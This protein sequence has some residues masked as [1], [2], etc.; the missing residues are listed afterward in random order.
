MIIGYAI[1]A[2]VLSSFILLVFSI[3]KGRHELS[4]L[5]KGNVNRHSLLSFAVIAGFFLMF[6]LLFVHP[7][8]QLYFDENIYQ[9][10]AVNI[11][12]SGQALWCQYGTGNLNVCYVDSLYH[13]PAAWSVF[14]AMAFGVFGTTTSTAYALELLVGILSIAGVFLLSSILLKNKYA[15]VFSTAVFALMPELFIWARTQADIDLPFMML[16][17]FAFF[18]FVVFSQKPNKKTFAMFSFSAVLAVYMRIEGILLIPLF[19]ILF[20][21]F[22]DSGILK[23]IKERLKLVA[24]AL[25]NDIKLL[26]LLVLVLLL[27]MPAIYYFSI[28]SSQPSYGQPS[29]QSVISL[30]NF[31]HNFPINAGYLL[32]EFNSIGNYPTAFP[33]LVFPL[34]LAGM[35]A[36]ALFS[37]RE[38]R[39]GIL[40][41]LV[42]WFATYFIFYTAFYAGAATYGVDVRF[43]LSLMPCIA[44]LAA[45]P[46]L[47]ITDKIEDSKSG[48][49]KSPG[50]K[51]VY[52]AII[53]SAF[54]IIFVLFPFVMLI[55]NVTILPQNMPQQSVILNAMNFFYANYS[56]VPSNCLV[57][58]F[59]PEI[60]Y[61]VNRT[62]AEINY[63]FGANQSLESTFK[64]YSC[65]VV[66]YGYW[67]V[68]PPY[69][70]TTC[71]QAKS[72]Y[73]ISTIAS[74]GAGNGETVAFY[75]IFG[76]S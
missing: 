67:C 58:S 23:T 15:A 11:L 30:N 10:I 28:E 63:L 72:A 53:F 43:M 26:L 7:A 19:L 42:F 50:R 20:F 48:E 75:R 57:F 56:K 8:E 1:T 45:L 71:A 31:M 38:N 68:V 34:A 3:I 47:V 49:S 65:V 61:N 13:D 60:W 76:F 62:S 52:K 55:P 37:R 5:I 39:F 59:T 22:G 41:L 64:N 18:F 24:N 73:P 40:L 46:L 35:A 70:S 54:A 25:L 29:N 21:A 6:S 66:D 51:P 69:E 33:V 36:V 9:G 32:G 27:L 74:A 16:T 12:H 4:Q 44:L 14:I 2:A 17:V